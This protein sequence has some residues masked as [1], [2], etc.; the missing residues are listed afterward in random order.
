LPAAVRRDVVK[1]RLNLGRIVRPVHRHCRAVNATCEAAESVAVWP[2]TLTHRGATS[3]LRTLNTVETIVPLPCPPA[4]RV[5][6]STVP[7]FGSE[8]TIPTCRAVKSVESEV[9]TNPPACYR[10]VAQY[11]KIA[12]SALVALD[13][14]A[15]SANASALV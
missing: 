1:R 4:S 10:A 2:D 3:G 6:V 14:Y 13:V 5:T 12:L 7:A 15:R 11:G 9:R 8:N